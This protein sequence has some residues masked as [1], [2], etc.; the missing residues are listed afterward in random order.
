[1]VYKAVRASDRHENLQFWDDNFMKYGNPSNPY[2]L[3]V[4]VGTKRVIFT[5]DPE[6][7]KAILATQFSDYGKGEHF[8]REW[9]EFLGDSE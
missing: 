4:H 5:V 8:N 6:N 3:E 7:I 2:T 9:Y 1:M